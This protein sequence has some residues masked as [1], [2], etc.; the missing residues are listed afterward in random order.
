MKLV[1]LALATA[2]LSVCASNAAAAPAKQASFCG[3]AKG[4]AA[5]LV[6]SNAVI[7]PTGA[8][9]LQTLERKLKVEYGA[10]VKAEPSLLGSAPGSIK[11]DLRKA[12]A[13]VNYVNGKMS[14]VN[15]DL[16]KLVA[17][18]KPLIAKAQAARPALTHLSTYFRRT[19]HI[20]GA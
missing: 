10:I 19:C 6:H 11:P 13:F 18:E 2:V 17:Y 12:L 4:V 15:W 3:T 5:Y 14:A 7:S 1:P 9:T 8:D 20:K 16:T